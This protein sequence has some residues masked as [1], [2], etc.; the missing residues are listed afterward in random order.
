MRVKLVLL[1][2]SA[3]LSNNLDDAEMVLRY[4]SF[5][6]SVRASHYPPWLSS[7]CRPGRF[8]S[9][10]NRYFSGSVSQHG[11]SASHSTLRLVRFLR[12][13][14]SERLWISF[15]L[16]ESSVRCWQLATCS[17]DDMLL[18]LRKMTL[19]IRPVWQTWITSEM[20]KWQYV[21]LCYSTL[22]LML[23]LQHWESQWKLRSEDTH[24]DQIIS[25]C[26][27]EWKQIL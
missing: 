17:R 11:F 16:R 3:E 18:A 12:C 21:I 23:K 15:R 20:E 1:V 9:T 8:L 22:T 14:S 13:L 10:D 25:V 7:F 26:N 27:K 5:V 4:H 19:K 6:V 24:H 2:S